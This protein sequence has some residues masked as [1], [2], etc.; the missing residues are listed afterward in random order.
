MEL[1]QLARDLNVSEQDR[2]IGRKTPP[3]RNCQVA[4]RDSPPMVTMTFQ[5]RCRLGSKLNI[6]F[7]CPRLKFYPDQSKFLHDSN[8]TIS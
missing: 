1:M 6:V 2:E 3:F 8:G 5:P 7:R 4:V